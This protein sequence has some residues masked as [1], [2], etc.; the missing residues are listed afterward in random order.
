[1]KLFHPSVEGAQHGDKGL[2]GFLKF[3]K[4]AGAEG[5]QPSCYMLQNAG[6]LPGKPFFPAA[7]I[8]QKFADA[9]LKL[10]GV[11]LHCLTWIVGT[12]WTGSKTIRPFIPKEVAALSPDKIEEWARTYCLNFFDLM[13]ELNVGVVPMFYGVSFGWEVATGYPWGFFQG[14]DYDLVKEGIDR[15]VKQYDAIHGL[16]DSN[17]IVLA[18]EIHP[19]TAAMCADDFLTLVES[20]QQGLGIMGV[21]A[22]PS[23]CWEGESWQDRFDKVGHRVYGCHV[24]N[25]HIRPGLPVRCMEPDWKK[26]P[27]QFT[28]L[29]QGDINL[30]RYTEQMIRIGYRD[31]YLKAMKLPDTATA[32]LVVE[33]EGAYE[34]LDDISHRGIQYVRDNLCFEVA[35]GSFEKGMGAE[36]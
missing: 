33:A 22:D 29:E 14:P 19:G 24:K 36:K 18:H 25:H 4:E 1:M 20:S 31:N 26:R 34:N 30:V 27:V 16:A 2:D 10:D 32:P 35:G 8:K 13:N 7:Y 28:A 5:C 23:H 12:A 9:Q 17:D 3:A 11:S 21:N 6:M 15:F